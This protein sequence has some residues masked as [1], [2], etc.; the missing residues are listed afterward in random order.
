MVLYEYV[1]KEQ[2]AGFDRYKYSAVDTNPLSVYV[3][4]PFWNFLVKVRERE[5]PVQ[6]LLCLSERSI[7]NEVS[8]HQ[9]Q[10]L[11]QW[12]SPDF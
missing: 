11:H 6:Y 2:L 1:T 7:I 3:M 5:S 8:S 4:H 10:C 12:T 9:P